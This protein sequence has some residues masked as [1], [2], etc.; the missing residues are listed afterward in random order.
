MLASSFMDPMLGLD[1]HWEMVPTPAPVPT[2]IPNPF[3]GIVFDPIGLA[4]GLAISNLIGA[5]LGDSFKGPVLFWGLPATNTG[6]EGKHVPGHILIP[7]GTAWAPVPRTPKPV[8]RPNET[9]KPP[10]PVSPDNDAVIVFGSKTVSVMGSNAV[11]MG[12]IA[13]SCSEPVRLPS[14]FVI[15]VPKGAPIVIGGP[16]SLDIM[17]AIMASLRTRFMSDS[18][19]ALISR[20][21]PSRFRN[22]LHRAACF[23][24]GHPVDVASGKVITGFLEIA[25]PGP[26][27]L[28]IERFYSSAF[29]GRRGPVGYGWSLSLDQAVW[30]EPGQV[31]YLAEDGREIVFDTFDLQG[32][33]MDVGDQIVHRREQMILR[34]DG[35]VT[36]SIT[37]KHGVRTEFAPVAREARRRA[38]IQRIATC[39]DRHAIRFAYRDDGHLK[40]VCDSAGRVV[41]FDHDGDGLITALTLPA[42]S[43]HGC[44][45]H[46]RYG[47]DDEGNL[48]SVADSLNHSWRF[49]YVTH[50]LV[51]ET[52]RAGFSFYFEYDGLGEDAWCTRTWG[53]GGAYDHKIQYDKKRRVTFVTDSRGFTT[54]YQANA[55]GAVTKIVDPL[56]GVRQLEWNEQLQPVSDTDPSGNRRAF[57]YDDCGYLSKQREPDGSSFDQHND[58]QGRL[59]RL[60]H[61][62]GMEWQCRYDDAGRLRETVAPTGAR[63]TYSYADADLRAVREPDGATVKVSYDRDGNVSGLDHDSGRSQWECDALGRVIA[64]SDGSGRTFKL[65]RDSEGRV[66]RYE[67]AAGAFEVEY[68]PDGQIVRVYGPEIDARF[69]YAFKDRV[70]RR[71]VGSEETIYESDAEGRLRRV[72]TAAGGSY[73]FHYSP[74]GDV[75]AA[76]TFDGARVEYARDASGQLTGIVEAGEGRRITRDACGRVDT[77][78]GLDGMACGFGYDAHGLVN[79]A[80][81]P[82]SMVRFKRN[83]AGQISQEEQGEHS[84]HFEY[85]R[86]GNRVSC[87][88]SLGV[89][90]TH[91][92]GANGRLAEI[93][94]S[95]RSSAR[96]SCSFEGSSRGRVERWRL[97]NDVEIASIWGREGRLNG[98]QATVAGEVVLNETLSWHAAG[99]LVGVRQGRREVAITETGTNTTIVA[100]EAG[101]AFDSR[102][103][104][105]FGNVFLVDD[106]GS[107]HYGRSGQLLRVSG[108]ECD[109]DARGQM[110]RKLLPDGRSW[111]YLWSSSGYL[112]RVIAPDGEQT[113]FT[114]DAL[115]RRIR[116]DSRTRSVH[117]IW[118]DDQILHEWETGP[119][120]GAL[121]GE[122]AHRL[123]TWVFL[124]ETFIPLVCEVDGEGPWSILTAVN[125]VPVAAYGHKGVRWEGEI[126]LWGNARVDTR[127]GPPDA[128]P[129]RFQNQYEDRETGLYYNRY[130]YYDPALGT[131]ISPDR[132]EVLRPISRYAYVRNPLTLADPYGLAQE[133]WVVIVREG[134]NEVV[135]DLGQ[136]R[137]SGEHRGTRFDRDAHWERRRIAELRRN[138][139][140]LEALAD[141]NTRLQF[142]S[143][144]STWHGRP[145]DACPTC[146]PAMREFLQELAD[147][148]GRDVNQIAEYAGTEGVTPIRCT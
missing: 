106:D 63:R 6:T 57:E 90:I 103:S 24:T 126:S 13:L 67:Q 110:V 91:R 30:E 121:R 142:W 94:F 132:D 122:S 58:E 144:G 76:V 96:W 25:L 78:R 21:S 54:T 123:K 115:G 43:G 139:Q 31:I 33:R 44:Y 129:W 47:Y 11:R 32:H 55:G 4:A 114:Y 10:K 134:T 34:R 38:M 61:S 26:L 130:R 119:A 145:L 23:L 95:D 80:G 64:T 141:P 109:Y 65:R 50:L 52:D 117:W 70:S 127:E 72:V 39:D 36:W 116:K 8:V 68:N 66:V 138:P 51:R 133:G 69:E 22:L 137:Y 86:R 3:T 62:G 146:Q 107:R 125:G 48:I 118:L 74:R 12:D 40:S 16:P 1:I 15:A 20:L 81:T 9:P 83:E 93:G 29:A 17:A 140:L 147:R 56:G 77:I 45:V 89:R 112:E 99:R 75:C 42:P 124:P 105:S 131:Y 18:L 85:D 101:I 108:I 27:P 28:R 19:H 60:Q 113:A 79:R 82:Q 14:T 148:F 92:Y 84:L 37:G 102:R 73:D 98:R 128:V 53:D 7:P 100:S 104:D 59:L 120:A 88:T 111:Q 97:P 71:T 143:L 35:D 136:S 5:C 87:A 49:E 2:P 41:Q 135:Q 46:R